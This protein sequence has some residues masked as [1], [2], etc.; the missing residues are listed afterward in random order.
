MAED[1]QERMVI[2][3]FSIVYKRYQVFVLLSVK[4][5]IIRFDFFGSKFPHR[6]RLGVVRH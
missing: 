2:L 6:L 3:S 1:D 4:T 5:T